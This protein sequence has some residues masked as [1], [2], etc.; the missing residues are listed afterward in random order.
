[1]LINNPLYLENYG[2][3]FICKKLENIK[4]ERFF[5]VKINHGMWEILNRQGFK[6]EYIDEYIANGEQNS[7]AWSPNENHKILGNGFLKE[8][9]TLL[10]NYSS[11]DQ[12]NGFYFLPCLD[13]EDAQIV[14]RHACFGRHY[15]KREE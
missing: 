2:F 4:N 15:S 13:Y 6:E 14:S 12:E 7:Y 9:L 10:K 5:F 11:K 8:I 3:D 1:M